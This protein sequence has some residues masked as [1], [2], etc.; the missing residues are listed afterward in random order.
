M[1]RIVVPAGAKRDV[2][3]HVAVAFGTAAVTT[4]HA[5]FGLPS[6]A[7]VWPWMV[8]AGLSWAIAF[9]LLWGIAR[10][11]VERPPSQL[12]ISGQAK[13]SLR[14]IPSSPTRRDD[15]ASAR[16]RRRCSTREG[17]STRPRRHA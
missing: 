14:A 10:A 15:E 4:L 6:G 16:A 12:V 8:V 13:P 1:T 7:E 9:G 11:G 3:V 2:L 17:N 5:A